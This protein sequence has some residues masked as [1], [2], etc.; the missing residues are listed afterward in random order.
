MN[1]RLGQKEIYSQKFASDVFS[2][3]TSLKGRSFCA[4]VNWIRAPIVSSNE[5]A[6]HRG[7]HW[8]A[9]QGM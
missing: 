8:R 3:F 5:L 4:E 2:T 7:L 9:S 1:S 6:I